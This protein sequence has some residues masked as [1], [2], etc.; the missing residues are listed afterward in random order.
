MASPMGISLSSSVVFFL[1]A[2]L[3]SPSVSLTC[4]SQ[5]F[6]GNALYPHCLDLPYLKAYLHFSY[7][8]G[9]STLA[10]VF[11]APPSKPGGWI[12]W[13]INPTA[14]G[15]SGAQSIVAFKDPKSAV[16]VVKT[17]NISSYAVLVPGKLA[18]DVWDTKA[19]E[20]GGGALRIFAKV[21]IP[22][23][24]AA[25]RKV[26]QVWQVG[27]GVSPTGFIQ[28]HGFDASNLNAMGTLDLSG[29]DN[30][31]V[32]GGG[33]GGQGDS[34]VRNRNI[35][36]ILNTVSWG[37][38]FPVGIIIARYMRTFESADP[39]WFYLHVLCQL[40]AYVIGV[41]GWATGLK[42]G[43][44]SKG[45]QYT[46][47]RNNG[48]ALFALATIQM[49]ALLLRPKKDHK[50]RFY[51]N[52]Y[53]HGIGYSI[54]IL[55]IFNVFKGLAILNPQTSYKTAYIVVISGLGGIALL[56]E[57]FTWVVVLKRKSSKST[58][59]LGA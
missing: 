13:A 12:A 49:F 47:H 46:S 27:P 7:D 4:T 14:E 36:G 11:S 34:R 32:A 5:T 56:L 19:E 44:E 39:A 48:I 45:I 41:A 38:L 40:S 54:L 30:G 57:A 1:W 33:G 8:A 9:N 23:D 53:H 31:A 25:K 10:V 16:A 24:L 58:N 18:F 17:L 29:A 52:I 6:S 3:I 51:W 26:N 22:A 35:H 42:L 20:D 43:S 50:Y 59:P 37:F 21:K 2:S 28:Q 15:M 55:G